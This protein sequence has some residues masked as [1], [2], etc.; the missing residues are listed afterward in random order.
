[1][2]VGVSG[3]YPVAIDRLAHE[4]VFWVNPGLPHFDLRGF[5]SVS[6][7]IP[8]KFQGASNTYVTDGDQSDPMLRVSSPL[9]D[10]RMVFMKE[11]AEKSVP[12]AADKSPRW[13]VNWEFEGLSEL[14]FDQRLP[15]NYRQMDPNP[16]GFDEK[17]LP[18]LPER[19]EFDDD[20]VQAALSNQS[21][22]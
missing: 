20:A 12:W 3:A 5:P 17:A 14:P 19:A 2:R 1:M 9:D 15:A 21:I 13:S 10:R 7:G 18:S 11:I 4:C 8:V 16:L 6:D 22:R